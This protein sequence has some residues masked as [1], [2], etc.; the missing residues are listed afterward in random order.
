MKRMSSHCLSHALQLY[1]VTLGA[2]FDIIKDRCTHLRQNIG[3]ALKSTALLE[4]PML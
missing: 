4:S 3:A 2:F 1:D